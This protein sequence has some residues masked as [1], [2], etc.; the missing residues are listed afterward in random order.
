[1][2]NDSVS[3]T[4]PQLDILVVD[5]VRLYHQ[6]IEK[7]FAGTRLR[8]HFAESGAAALEMVAV[9]TRLDAVPE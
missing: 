8:P 3:G 6:I 7:V 4:P 9:L 1:M 2:A 5:N